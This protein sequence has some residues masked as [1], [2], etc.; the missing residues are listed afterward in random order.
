MKY[1]VTLILAALML[2]ILSGTYIIG[3]EPIEVSPE[4][5][6][7]RRMATF[8]IIF[9]PV[10]DVNSELYNADASFS[11]RVENAMKDQI[12][13]RPTVI[14][15]YNALEHRMGSIYSNLYL[16]L[17]P[18]TPVGGEDETD[19]T[20]V[21]P[22]IDI[23][24]LP[25][26]YYDLPAKE[27]PVIPDELD[28]DTYP[29]YGYERLSS[30]KPRQYSLVKV[31][32]LYRINDTDWLGTAPTTSVS[33]YKK[34]SALYQSIEQMKTILETY[35]YIKMYN[36]YVSQS[37]HTPW[38]DDYMGVTSVD[39]YEYITRYLP[40]E[41]EFDQFDY[42]NLAEYQLYNYKG[43]HHWSH[44]GSEYGYREVYAMMA[45]DLD[46]S[47]LKLP[48]K[49][50]N[51]TELYGVEYRGSR[52]RALS[53]SIYDEYDEF[54]VYEYDLGNRK[55]YA[56]DPATMKEIPVT[57]TLMEHYKKGNI[58]TSRTY[59]HYIN[60][61]GQSYDANGKYYADSSVLYK[62]VNPDSNTGHN[63]LIVG[64]STQRAY[65]DTLASHFD[66]TIYF[67]YRVMQST[68]QGKGK[69]YIDYIIEEYDIDTIL[70]GGL[71]GSYWYSSGYKFTFSPGF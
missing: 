54:L 21:P 32:S 17:N 37:G 51:F 10:T 46:L 43:D 8:D 23:S 63:L 49:E 67:D 12:T 9:N 36:Y 39:V 13:I 35:P 4:D 14:E 47:P 53:E 6:E 31:G 38:F 70:I 50:W 16:M 52:A 26:E 40:E 18:P 1:R 20:D 19:E 41:V 69:A 42:D 5:Q 30:F 22:I 65:R 33:Q 24:G 25:D 34:G 68:Y 28:F 2:L 44:L 64:D 55:T 45:D 7:N 27:E 60:F 3:Y 57:L 15:L 58:S 11:D 59:D 56:I 48:V 62:I 66:T 29:I 61:Y 71:P